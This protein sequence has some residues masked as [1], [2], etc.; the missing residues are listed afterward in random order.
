[1]KTG[2]LPLSPTQASDKARLRALRAGKSSAPV[3]LRDLGSRAKVPIYV[4]YVRFRAPTHGDEELC[5]YV[6]CFQRKGKA[7]HFIEE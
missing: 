5:E 4:I 3:R 1:M 6:I 2:E 7:R